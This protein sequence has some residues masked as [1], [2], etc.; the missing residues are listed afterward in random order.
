[1]WAR[2]AVAV[3]LSV[4]AGGSAQADGVGRA[5]AELDPLPFAR[6]GYGGQVGFRPAGS[7]LRVAAASFALDVP[8]LAVEVGGNDGFHAR[9]R[10]SAAL[11]LLYHVQPAARGG[12]AFGG[13]LRYL[14]IRY[15]HDDEPDARADVGDLS[16]ELI[17]GY[18][19]H[20]GAAGFYLQPWLGLG[21]TAWRHG[22]L[23][24]G[25]HTYDPLPVQPFFTVNV[26]WDVAL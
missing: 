14:R 11:Y 4:A 20:P 22:D 24:V 2:V 8:D 10:P 7:G 13:S 19:W 9:V 23:D 16:P 6:G 12:W 21:V 15:T 1:M 3:V 5:H 17:A 18:K 26:G 25:A